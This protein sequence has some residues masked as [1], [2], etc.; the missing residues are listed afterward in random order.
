MSIAAVVHRN[1]F[2]VN[3]EA[4]TECPQ[5]DLIQF[6]D[7]HTICYPAGC[8]IV[9]Y[10]RQQGTNRFIPL[11]EKNDA[12]TAMTVSGD[13]RWLAVAER[14]MN[15]KPNVTIYDLNTFRK[16]KTIVLGLEIQA[17]VRL[18]FFYFYP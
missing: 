15:G 8:N 12:I 11:S 1:V 16:R 13:R 3:I 14:C 10:D 17:T 7:E 4:H 18:I 9:V 2:G 6:I 5:R